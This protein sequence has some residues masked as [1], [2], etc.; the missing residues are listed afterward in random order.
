MFALT[1]L[2]GGLFVLPVLVTVGVFIGVENQALFHGNG[3]IGSGWFS[4]GGGG[5]ARI[6]T[7]T[8]CQKSYGITPYP[9]RYI[10][11]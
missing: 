10:C 9:G 11:E 2:S 1:L 5:G 8:Y 7:Q 6:T 4:P 3:Q